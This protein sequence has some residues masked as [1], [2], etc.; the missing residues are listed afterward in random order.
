LVLKKIIDI[1]VHKKNKMSIE[2]LMQ[3]AAQIPQTAQGELDLINKINT[4]VL[5]KLNGGRY[6]FLVYKHE[7][8]TIT[9]EEH[10]EWMQLA[11]KEEKIR[12]ER[13]TYIVELAKRKKMPILQLM[14]TFNLNRT[15]TA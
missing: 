15:G 14:D 5:S 2:I 8:E 12:V 9:D 4:I 7:F 6:Q 3:R 1:F 11:D 13:L 10:H